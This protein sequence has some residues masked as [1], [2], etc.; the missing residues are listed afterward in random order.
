MVSLFGV[1]RDA[2]ITFD[3]MSIAPSTRYSV[4][5]DS[6]VGL[7][8]RGS[9]MANLILVFMLRGS[10]RNWKQPIGY[11]LISHSVN[12]P[13]LKSLILEGLRESHA[14]GIRVSLQ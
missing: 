3:A 13:T 12:A 4:Q 14:A 1:F 10:Y 2:V 5:D 6:V 9:D 11:H 7:D 8:G